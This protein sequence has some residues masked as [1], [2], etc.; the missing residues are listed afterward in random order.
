MCLSRCVYRFCV[1][2]DELHEVNFTQPEDERANSYAKPVARFP[3]AIYFTYFLSTA[4]GTRCTELSILFLISPFNCI[5]T[6]YINDVS[7]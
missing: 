5:R 3:R 4:G 7:T 1:E 2:S 6:E